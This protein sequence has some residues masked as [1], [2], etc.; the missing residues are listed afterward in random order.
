MPPAAAGTLA[1]N[2][3]GGG[4]N[5]PVVA[6]LAGGHLG[7][8]VLRQLRLLRS[9]VGGGKGAEALSSLFPSDSVFTTG[10]MLDFRQNFTS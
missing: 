2:R 7:A 10:F 8:R 6:R 9:A 5:D 3:A 4:V 1:D